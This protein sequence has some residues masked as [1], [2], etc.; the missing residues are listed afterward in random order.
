ML[1]LKLLKY[2]DIV[3]IYFFFL[4]VIYIL[5]KRFEWVKFYL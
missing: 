2:G 1:F 3:G 4:L 5:L